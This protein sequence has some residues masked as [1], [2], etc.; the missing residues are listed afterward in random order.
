MRM[1]LIILPE[2]QNC[3]RQEQILSEPCWHS[4]YPPSQGITLKYYEYIFITM[5]R[6]RICRRI[7]CE[8]GVTYFKPRGVP[9]ARLENVDL[10]IDEFEAIRLKDVEHL[11]Q[12][13]AAEKMQI[14]QPTFHRVI[15]SARNKV[16]DALI[17][18][19]AIRIEGADH[20]AP[21]A[22]EFSCHDCEHEW[23]EPRGT[24]RPA[25]CPRCSSVRIHRVR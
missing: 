24:G 12:T 15:E 20:A 11:D 22:R 8:P 3:S 14:S 9:L 5:P 13:A 18:G 17:N 1:R 23:G 21:S 25:N 4:L 19:K 7:N 2:E 16:A 6:P 10:T